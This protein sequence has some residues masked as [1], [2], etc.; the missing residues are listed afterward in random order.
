MVSNTKVLQDFEVV[1]HGKLIV[2]L[3]QK[4][5]HVDEVIILK[6][7]V[8]FVKDD[9]LL[10]EIGHAVLINSAVWQRLLP[11]VHEMQHRILNQLGYLES[12]N[13]VQ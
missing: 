13:G 9:V 12:N 6:N 10:E 5:L 1:E 4:W 3:N 2:C 11:I 8:W 7:K